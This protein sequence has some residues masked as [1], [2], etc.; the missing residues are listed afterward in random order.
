MEAEVEAL[1]A[2]ISGLQL[3]IE[4]ARGRAERL[5]ER[6]GQGLGAERSSL[7]G[8]EAGGPALA[9]WPRL[10]AAQYVARIV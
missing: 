8:S 4:T 1:R 6:A 7:L 2:Q 10:G 9:H 5:R 3:Q